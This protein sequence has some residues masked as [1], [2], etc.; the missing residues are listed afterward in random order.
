MDDQ[1]KLTALRS[2]LVWMTLVGA[3]VFVFLLAIPADPKNAR[4]LGYSALR[5]GMLAFSLALLAVFGWAAIGAARGGLRCRQAI[6]ILSRIAHQALFYGLAVA[7]NGGLLVVSGAF[8]LW[9][10][11][12]A[13]PTLRAYLIRFAPFCF[14]LAAWSAGNFYLLIAY[15]AEAGFLR[16]LVRGP[17]LRSAFLLCV[18]FLLVWLISAATGLG[19][20]PDDSSWWG[21]GWGGP[22]VPILNWQ[23]LLAWGIGIGCLIAGSIGRVWMGKIQR[24]SPSPLIARYFSTNLWP[25]VI[26][27]LAATLLWS[28]E[29]LRPSW[30]LPAPRNPNLEYYPYSDAARH[31][32]I[33]Q[34]ILVGEGFKWETERVVRRPLYALYLAGLH[35]IAG[36]DYQRVI[37][38]QVL[39][40]AVFPALIY[41]LGRQVHSRQA[42]VIAAV[43]IG[44]RERNS[45]ALS[46]VIDVS[47]AKLLMTDLPLAVGI[48]LFTLVLVGW[49]KRPE[50]N[51]QAPLLAGGIL[52][53]LMLI[54]PQI[55][56]VAAVPAMIGWFAYHRSLPSRFEPAFFLLVGISAALIPWLLR[57]WQL[58]GTL[59]LDETSQLSTLARHY[60]NTPE[61]IGDARLPGETE[62]EYSQRMLG[63]V[64]Q[65]V[66]EDPAEVARFILS[67]FVRNEID[68][69]LIF[70]TTLRQEGLRDYVKRVPYWFRWDGSLLPGAAPYLVLSICLL[71][72]GVA[73]ALR[74]PVSAGLMPL[75]IGLAYSLSCAIARISGWRFILPAD[76]AAILYFGIGLS[77]FTAL[78]VQFVSGRRSFGG[79]RFGPAADPVDEPLPGSGVMKPA[80]MRK[81]VLL[82][83]TAIFLVGASLPLVEWISQPRYP[84]V[85]KAETLAYLRQVGKLRGLPDVAVTELK[86][87]LA[88][89]ATVVFWGRALYPGYY[90][91]G[92]GEAPSWPDFGPR[93]C[94]RVEFYLVGPQNAHMVLPVTRE[95]PTL[96]DA[97]DVLVVGYPADGALAA[98][99]V[100]WFQP[101][102]ALWLRS[103]IPP[104]ACQ[105][106]K[107][108]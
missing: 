97:A 104:L 4:F 39:C 37:A 87:A 65:S 35:L 54:R 49:L 79:Y 106:V 33:A 43:L 92:Q 27:W 71:A 78:S 88:D 93:D 94:D 80:V 100:M 25:A 29:P 6:G 48:A 84:Q 89:Q 67:N 9:A 14:W 2:Y 22:G 56:L 20:R 12:V 40:L 13:D 75:W 96:P 70:P 42:G 45:I 82:L 105:P 15:H 8:L 24:G 72:L 28:V 36:Q 85:P 31:D 16:Q 46:N 55:A 62:A 18:A 66:R 95:P 60:S 98:T 99:V 11:E 1:Q 32:V 103:S 5:L 44:L 50:R 57:N 19:L 101:G 74:K 76:W 3:A 86:N 91:A 17:V 64:V 7:F 53:L 38:L 41:L 102:E 26:I 90:R 69:L 68:M 47:H 108:N 52:G 77:Q 73:A 23:I 30:F 34:N 81:K 59:A 83:T 63:L 21:R 107:I 10:N 61:E 58:T 51:R